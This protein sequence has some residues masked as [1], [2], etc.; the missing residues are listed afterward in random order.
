MREELWRTCVISGLVGLQGGGRGWRNGIR[1]N[2]LAALLFGLGHFPQG[3]TGV[4]VTTLLGFC[5]GS[6]ML[7]HRSTWVA[8][9]AHGFFDALTFL[10]LRVAQTSGWLEGMHARDF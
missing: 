8:V 1:A 7:V 9:L 2:A 10:I 5:L 4:L 6:V 3:W